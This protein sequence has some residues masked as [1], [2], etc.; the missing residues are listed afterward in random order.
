MVDKSKPNRK[1][2]LNHTLTRQ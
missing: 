2:K 1:M